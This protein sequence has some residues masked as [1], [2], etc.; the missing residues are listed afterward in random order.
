[1][2]SGFIKTISDLRR[3]RAV[4]DYDARLA[5]LLAACHKTGMKG[6][7]QV[8]LQVEPLDGGMVHITEAIKVNRP[9]KRGH[10]LF[11]WQSAADDD[12]SIGRNDPSQ[13][14]LPFRAVPNQSAA[15][16]PSERKATNG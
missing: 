7:I 8:T 15:E 14:E 16:E 13:P 11:F 9:E 6:L 12:P 2:T 3:G 10:T 1:M 5:D 4:E